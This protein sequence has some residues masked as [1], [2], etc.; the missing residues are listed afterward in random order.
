[1]VVNLGFEEMRSHDALNYR[2]PTPET[3]IPLTLAQQVVLLMGQ[4][5]R[6]RR[7]SLGIL[8]VIYENEELFIRGT[9]GK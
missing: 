6:V 2:P 1:M 3:I 8:S 5:S 9:D 7:N 4:V